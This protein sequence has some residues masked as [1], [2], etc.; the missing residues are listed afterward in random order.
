MWGCR[1]ESGCEGVW[2]VTKRK[3]DGVGMQKREYEGVVVWKREFV[4]VWRCG[5]KRVNE[6]VGGGAKKES[7]RVRMSNKERV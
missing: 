5:R 4:R 3:Y 2:G 6:G 1:G 7:M